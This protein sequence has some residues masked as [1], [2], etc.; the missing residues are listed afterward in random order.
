MAVLLHD[1]VD[2]RQ[3]RHALGQ[4][5][6]DRLA[7]VA[8]VAGDVEDVVGDLEG[9]AEV[10]SE[11]AERGDVLRI[12][13]GEQRGALAARRVEARGLQLDALEIRVHRWNVAF[14]GDLLQLAV[15]EREHGLR[16]DRDH[17][18][19]GQHRG[20][21]VRL[22]EE[23]IADDERR[24]I[25][26]HGV[27]RRDIPAHV[28]AVDDVV[29]HQGRGVHELERL[30]AE[31]RG[32]EHQ[33]RSEQLPGRREEV[34]D[35]GLEGGMGAPTDVEQ[36]PFELAQLGIDRRVERCSRDRPH[37]RQSRFARMRDPPARVRW[38]GAL[39]RSARDASSAAASASAAADRSARERRCRMDRGIRSDRPTASAR[40]RRSTS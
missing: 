1:R 37:E 26:P 34:L 38:L 22:G 23:V 21:R 35:G 36:T 29:M 15:A 24:V 16:D 27:D 17:L 32:E 30:R 33:R 5:A 12:R 25:A 9:E 40:S 8:V 39:C 13:V 4:I 20:E 18:G 6:S 2:H 7:E 31:A 28:G 11:P 19:L 3:R 14:H 10:R